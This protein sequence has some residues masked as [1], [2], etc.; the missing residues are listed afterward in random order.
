MRKLVVLSMILGIA[1]FANAAPLLTLTSGPFTVTVW[2]ATDPA[3][4]GYD[5]NQGAIPDGYA[6]MDIAVNIDGGIDWT[7][8]QMLSHLTSGSFY[9][10]TTY[11]GNVHPNPSFYA[12]VPGLA[13][14]TY[15][16]ATSYPGSGADGVTNIA[17]GAV[18]L[19]GQSSA[20]MDTSLLDV[21]WFDTE[22][23]YPE[24][25]I[26]RVTYSND[27]AGSLDLLVYD[28]AQDKETFSIPIP[29]IVPEP[30]SIMLM[31]VGG[32]V[33]LIRRR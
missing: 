22:S 32:V 26:A 3:S 14:D 31:L 1:A 11:G 29:P 15:V 18:N 28:A 10:D 19:G 33:G 16:V 5:S 8:A 21:T 4:P 6:S 20:T 2:D 9:Q 23:V 13:F 25:Q 30:V 12:L 27:A 17:G 24:G 7:Q